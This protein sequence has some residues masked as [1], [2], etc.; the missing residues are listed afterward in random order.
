MT[1]LI[2]RKGSTFTRVL[3]WES[4]PLVYT[5]ITAISKSAPV[6]ITAA[7]H[8]L[9][10][11]W[12]AAVTSPG[13]MRQIK[14]KSFPPRTSDMHAVTVISSSQVSFNDVDSTGFSTFTS[15]G[16]LV[17]YT[18]VSLAG[19]SARMQIRDTAESTGDPLV[20]LVSPGDIALDDTAHTITVTI[21]AIA[22][23]AFAWETGVFDLELVSADGVVT[24]I[25]DG[26]V[27]AVDEVT[28]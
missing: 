15:G 27:F 18:P 2:I 17:S 20:S 23:A 9:T 13:G 7:A 22:T 19:Y 28:R 1:D 26:N 14:A 25:L 11:G 5:P 24:K 12:R 16:S 3:R 6:V 10:D 8:G 21:S 4:L